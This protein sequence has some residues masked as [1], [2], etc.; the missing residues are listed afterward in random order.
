MRWALTVV[1]GLAAASCGGGTELSL[2]ELTT[3]SGGL[4]GGASGSGGMGAVAGMGGDSGASGGS[5]G[6]AGLSGTGGG[7]GTGGTVC[8]EP[9]TD[10][11]EALRGQLFGYGADTTGGAEG[12]LVHV[13]TL[14]DDPNDPGSLRAILSQEGPAWIVFDQDGTIDLTSDLQVTSNKTIDGQGRSVTLA[15][16]GLRIGP[17]VRNVIVESLTFDGNQTLEADDVDGIW[18]SEQGSGQVWINHVAI[19]GYFDEHIEV[20]NSAT[21]VTISWSYFAPG[22]NDNSHALLF[23]DDQAREDRGMLITMHHNWFDRIASYAPRLRYG[24]VHSYNNWFD[25][26]EDY[27]SGSSLEGHLYSEANVYTRGT[28]EE[29]TVV[30]VNDNEDPGF[31]I[32]FN[33][34]PENDAEITEAP[35]PM[36]VDFVYPPYPYTP[37]SAEIVKELVQGEAGPRLQP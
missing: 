10:R 3:G 8:V 18:I 1:L 24:V 34:L 35:P 19:F 4:G 37:D 33:D 22:D 25:R 6:S 32:S 12:C 23:G 13:T 11:W 21:G 20:S 28:A 26:W 31:L 16:Y 15:R 27:A 9:A 29:A 7:G 2:G 36:G 17:N 5:G 14:A 30:L